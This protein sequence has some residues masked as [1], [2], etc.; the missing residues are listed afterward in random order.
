MVHALLKTTGSSIHNQQP[1]VMDRFVIVG[2]V[3]IDGRNDFLKALEAKGIYG[4][5]NKQDIEIVLHGW[6][7]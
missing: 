6:L 3:R 4:L 5:E 1:F 7:L 2:D